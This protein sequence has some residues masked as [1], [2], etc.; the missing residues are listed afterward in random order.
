MKDSGEI[1]IGD[2]VICIAEPAIP[3][4]VGHKWY[5]HRI[6]GDLYYC[7]NLDLYQCFV[8]DCFVFMK[9][10][11]VPVTPLMEELL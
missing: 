11:I 9:N 2:Y 10:E 1:K 5:V 3:R 6:V 4:F 7:Q 8:D